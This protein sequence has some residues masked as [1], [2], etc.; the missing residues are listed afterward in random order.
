MPP[1]VEHTAAIIVNN[2][3]GPDHRNFD[4]LVQLVFFKLCKLLSSIVSC[5]GRSAIRNDSKL[6]LFHHTSLYLKDQMAV[7]AYKRRKS[8]STNN[9]EEKRIS[10]IRRFVDFRHGKR[11]VN[12]KK[13][14]CGDEHL[15]CTISLA[16][17]DSDANDE[18]R[19]KLQIFR[20]LVYRG[21]KT[22]PAVTSQGTNRGDLYLDSFTSSNLRLD[23]CYIRGTY[24]SAS[25]A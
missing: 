19:A 23:G 8:K 3:V 16:F 13:V 14:F 11:N 20:V 6:S 12:F 1:I 25:L 21:F 22:P 10:M 24:K 4:D 17:A 15:G 2:S 9:I 18:H 7:P 5:L